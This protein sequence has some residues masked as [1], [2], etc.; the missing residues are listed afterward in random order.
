MGLL[1]PVP[2]KLATSR[3]V[4]LNLAEIIQLCRVRCCASDSLRRMIKAASSDA[5]CEIE[6]DI[7]GACSGAYH[8]REERVKTAQEQSFTGLQQ[9]F[10]LQPLAVDVNTESTYLAIRPHGQLCEDVSETG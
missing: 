6:P 8:S 4:A 9:T 10:H 7:D 2:P 5:V 3:R 1:R